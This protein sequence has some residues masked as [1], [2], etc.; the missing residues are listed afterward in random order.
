M[1]ILIV[2]DDTVTRSMLSDFVKTMNLNPLT[3]QDGM[4][5]LEAFKKY[6]PPIV[7]T[8]IRMPKMGGLDLVTAIKN[9]NPGTYLTVI[10]AYDNPEYTIEAFKR[11]ASSFLTK[12]FRVLEL[13]SIIQKQSYLFSESATKIS[14]QHLVQQKNVKLQMKSTLLYMQSILDHL[15]KECQSY[16]D[17]KDV[18]K[19]RKALM[20]MITNAIEHGNLEI[21]EEEKSQ[22]I[23]KQ[24]YN[25][26]LMNRLKS[27]PYSLRHVEIEFYYQPGFLQWIISDQGK[28]FN[29]DEYLQPLKKN[30]LPNVKGEGIITSFFQVDNLYYEDEGRRVIIE[31][32]VK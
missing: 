14:I 32:T 30:Q 21:T 23:Q 8:D 31:K 11:G 6:N 13:Y 28:G 1:N 29:Y 2:E 10:T 27:E 26:V 17:P 3:A 24:N 15:I 12:P 7:I 16:I 5:G 20:E 9:Q 19:I 22:G 4:E 25:D 18:Y